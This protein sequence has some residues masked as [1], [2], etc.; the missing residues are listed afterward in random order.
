LQSRLRLSE[1]N[2]DGGNATMTAGRKLTVSTTYNPVER[3]A[4][5]QQASEWRAQEEKL[6]SEVTRLQRLCKNQVSNYHTQYRT[7]VLID[8]LMDLLNEQ[9]DQL[10]SQDTTIRDLRRQL[11][12]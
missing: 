10:D 5:D 9:A 11:M 2:R 8:S 4:A 6:K 3:F 12:G 1:D 7:G